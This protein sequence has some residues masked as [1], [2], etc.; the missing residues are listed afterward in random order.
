MSQQREHEA[1]LRLFR[2]AI[3]LMPSHAYAH[4]LCGHERLA[5]EDLEG[6]VR[7]ICW[8]D[9]ANWPYATEVGVSTPLISPMRMSVI[10]I[11]NPPALSLPRASA[12][13]SALTDS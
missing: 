4:T 2:R 6:A 10:T 8:P 11:E 12:P 7:C 5:V 3:Q 13:P 9:T 1:A